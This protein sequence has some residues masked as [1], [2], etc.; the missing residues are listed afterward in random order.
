MT[1]TAP[2]KGRTGEPLRPPLP[3]TLA[4]TGLSE[5]VVVD[6]MLKALYLQGA[7]TGQQ[8]METIR[9]PFSFLD[10]Q[11]LSLQQRRLVE[12]RGTRGP[13]RGGY[14]F[15]LTGEGR[16]RAREALESSQ[17]VGPA[18]VPLSQYR[19]WCR[20]QSISRVHVSREDVRKGFRNMVLPDAVLEMLGPAIN[21]AKSL[22]LYGGPG[23]G[24]TFIAQTISQL[25]GGNLY[26]PYALE[27]EG[28]ILVLYDSVYHH[29]V[30]EAEPQ[31]EGDQ[32]AWL[33]QLPEHDRRYVLVRR[34][35]VVTG[36]ELTLDQLDLRYDAFTKMY[37]AP[38]QLKANGGVL[39]LDDFGRQ[40]TSPRD[41]LNRW[42]VPLEQRI[43]YLALHTGGKFPVPFDCLLIFSTNLSPHELVEEAFL[44]RIHYKLHVLGPT[45]ESLRE[46]FRRCCAERE[47]P[48]EDWAVPHLYE[49]YYQARGIVPRNCHPRDVL[50][51]FLDLV[52]YI[53]APAKLTPELLDRACNSYF[54]DAPQEDL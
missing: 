9:L 26:I 13:G 30:A 3:K 4:D 39:I 28:Q 5:E 18:P 2:K 52:R 32:P 33:K 17:Y 53:G 41:L 31:V 37:Q 21:S 6:L 43:D 11:L 40:R 50:D 36:G 23:D 15:D 27:V 48:C 45:E 16:T 34:P 42:I 49:H 51:H 22:F 14:L 20:H 12:V 10:D 46:I 47:I 24:K 44:R 29:E 7:R 54:L 8:L 19:E 38:F 25:L 35:V 1:A